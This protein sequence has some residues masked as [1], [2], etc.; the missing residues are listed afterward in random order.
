MIEVSK[1]KWCG[2]GNYQIQPIYSG[3]S[4]TVWVIFCANCRLQ[5]IPIAVDRFCTIA[6]VQRMCLGKWNEANIDEK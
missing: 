6:D 1:C 4:D 5:T 2:L 3:P